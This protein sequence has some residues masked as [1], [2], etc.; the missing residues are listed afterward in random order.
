[1]G[2]DRIPPLHPE[3]HEHGGWESSDPM[4][5][6]LKRPRARQFSF[7]P[8]R[9]EIAGYGM[10]ERR[11]C[12]QRTTGPNLSV[13]VASYFHKAA[14]PSR[15]RCRLMRPCSM[16]A[17]SPFFPRVPILRAT[18]IPAPSMGAYTAPSPKDSTRAALKTA[19]CA[20][21]MIARAEDAGTAAPIKSGRV[22]NLAVQRIRP[23]AF[24]VSNLV[25]GYM[26]P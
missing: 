5:Q 14:P 1:M 17:I 15:R 20:H 6:G 13:G 2:G 3:R 19:A 23:R 12:C 24:L 22:A 8:S 11:R 16:E 7:V 26:V 4:L 18:Q 9:H 25:Q 10:P 21:G